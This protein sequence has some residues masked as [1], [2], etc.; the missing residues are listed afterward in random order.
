MPAM[1]VIFDEDGMPLEVRGVKLV[2]AEVVAAIGAEYWR[3]SG[4]VGEA[5]GARVSRVT[6]RAGSLR[7]EMSFGA[8]AGYAILVDEGLAQLLEEEDAS[9][10]EEQPEAEALEA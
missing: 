6:V 7:L 3:L 8:E 5:L 2:D 4:E 10:D 1:L 9:G